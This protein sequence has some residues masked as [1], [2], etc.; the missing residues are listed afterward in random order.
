MKLNQLT[1]AILAAGFAAQASAAGFALSEQSVSA[2]GTANAGRA[3]DAVD[4][5]VVYNNPAAMHKLKQAQITTNVS[6]IDADT[7]IKNQSVAF[8]GTVAGNSKGDIVPH[9]FIPSGF[10]T[11][12]D[13]G[14]WAYGIG[15]YGSFGLKTNHD[16]G[17]AGR[18]LGNKSDVKVTTIQP[19]VSYKVHDKVSVGAGITINQIQAYLSSN[20]LDVNPVVTGNNGRLQIEGND[21]GY[22]FN[23][24][25]HSD[26]TENTQVGLIY[27][28]KVKYK[29]DNGEI[30]LGAILSGAAGGDRKASATTGIST[31]ESVELALTHALDSKTKLHATTS[32]TR[33]S[34]F[35]SLDV[36]TGFPGPLAN[37]GE[38]FNWKDSMAY[39][40]GISH[41]LDDKL[42]VRAGLAYDNTPVAPAVRS[43]RLPSGDRRVVSVGAGYALTP[44]QVIDVS[45]MYVDE[46]RADVNRP[47]DLSGAIPV[48]AY[49]ASFQN[50]ASIYGVQYTLKF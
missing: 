5:S 14:G 11:S 26:V 9:T 4:A 39:A 44:N 33:W 28:S 1:V 17:F 7:K 3:S 49:S 19:A 18:Y 27:R 45:Y 29:I 10:F 21:V 24:A 50:S 46:E 2:N 43:V 48:P 23:L 42:T 25:L 16:D 13:Q 38:E 47:T 37:V 40:V 22:G 20:P 8:G 35:K 31:P 6:F 34:R 36:S 30:R 15:A 32:W 12:G 41:A